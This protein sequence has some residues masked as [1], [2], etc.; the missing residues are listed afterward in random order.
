MTGR[1]T[2]QARPSAVCVCVCVRVC[3]C[4]CVCIRCHGTNLLWTA[5]THKGH[6]CPRTA[7]EDEEESPMVLHQQPSQ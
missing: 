3:V 4:V 7:V 1:P 5:Q 6:S 2:P